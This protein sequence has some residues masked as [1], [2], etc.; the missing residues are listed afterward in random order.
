MALL[1]HDIVLLGSRHSRDAMVRSRLIVVILIMVVIFGVIALRLGQFGLQRVETAIEGRERDAITAGR[2]AL[3]DRNGLELALDI[4]VPS[5]FAEPRRIVDVDE[6]VSKLRT[7]LP[8]VDPTWLRDRL[9]G[10][11]GFVWLQREVSPSVGEKVMNLGLPG[12]DLLTE[13]SRFYP[14]GSESAHVV[15]SVNIDSQGI[16]GMERALDNEGVALLQNIGLA[17]EQELTPTRLSVDLRVQYAMWAELSDALTR[18][19]AIAAAGV[20]LDARTGEVIGLVSLPDFD[21]NIPSSALKDGRMNR[22]TAGTFELGSTFKSIAFAAALDSGKVTLRDSFDA[23]FGV[24][25]GRFTITDFHG[26]NRVL[27]LPEIYKYSSNVGAIH[28]VEALGKDAYRAFLTTLGFDDPLV[29]ELPERARTNVPAKF[30]EITAA[31]ASFG[32][33]LSITPLHMAAAMAAL[34]N[35]G[36]Y[37]VP[38]FYPRNV[39]EAGKRY[40]RV[41]SE[42][43]SRKLRYLMRLNALDGSGTRMNKIAGGFRAGGKTGTAEKV[44]DGRYAANTNLNTFAA[45]FPMDDPRY[46]LLVLVDEPKAENPQSGTTAG[47]NAGEVVGRIIQRTAPMMGIAPNFDPSLDAALLPEE[48]VGIA[49]Q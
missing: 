44:V 25:F 49:I 24:R 7:A 26:Q 21:P 37:V 16:S 47:W 30:S 12:V 4:R 2:P 9:S 34:V 10:E 38:T 19:Q 13:S 39:E 46:V 3:L 17:R 5:I 20:M 36:N 14:G 28:I 40:R 22:I 41:I 6:A 33:G 1:G 31:T 48:L 29:T 8:D 11:K 18:Y 23:R 42:E 32:H 27:T 35:G 15:G 45:A 43:T